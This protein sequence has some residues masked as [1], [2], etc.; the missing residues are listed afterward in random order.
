MNRAEIQKRLDDRIAERQRLLEQ[1]NAMLERLNGAI[2]EL[3]ALLQ[4]ADEQS[5]EDANGDT[6]AQH[7]S[8]RR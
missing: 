1:A 3:E 7:T 5:R 4:S 2:A 6:T 8:M